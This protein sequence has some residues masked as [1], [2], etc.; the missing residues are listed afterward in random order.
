MSNVENM[1]HEKTL[2]FE[3][4]CL[5]K[6]GAEAKLVQPGI[7][8]ACILQSRR[9]SEKGGCP[10]R[11]WPLRHAGVLPG[12]MQFWAFG[13]LERWDKGSRR[14]VGGR[15]YFHPAPADYIFWGFARYLL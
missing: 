1:R 7:L 5:S 6:N 4:Y 14:G 3:Y 2:V 8:R 13:I 12:V 9:L 15:Q 10:A 11:P